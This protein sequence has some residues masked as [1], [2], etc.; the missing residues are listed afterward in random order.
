MSCEDGSTLFAPA[1]LWFF[2]N[3]TVVDIPL[4]DRH[5]SAGR[6]LIGA[7]AKIVKLGHPRPGVGAVADRSPAGIIRSPPGQL[8]ISAACFD[9]HTRHVE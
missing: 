1:K 8:S 7:R 9:A 4:K 2:K 6:T 3:N 5:E